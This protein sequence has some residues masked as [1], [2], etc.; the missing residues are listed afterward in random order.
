[1]MLGEKEGGGRGKIIW[2]C[3]LRGVVASRWGLY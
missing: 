3:S 1:M 2:K